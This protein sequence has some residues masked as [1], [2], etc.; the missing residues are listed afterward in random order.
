MTVKLPRWS[1]LPEIGLYMDQVLLVLNGALAPLNMEVTS[2]MINNY[3]KMKLTRSALKKKYGRDQLASF[4]VICLMKKNLSMPEISVVMKHF[5]MTEASFD[6]FCSELELRL[7]KLD[8]PDTP[9]M[10]PL[11]A[12][13]IRG[14]ACKIVAEEELKKYTVKS[15]EMNEKTLDRPE[16]SC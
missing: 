10:R 11:L 12:A 3:V 1:Q 8:G 7:E 5:G 16:G 6:R 2:T 13:V 4:F 15:A 9:G 14:V